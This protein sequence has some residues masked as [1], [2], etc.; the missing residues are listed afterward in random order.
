MAVTGLGGRRGKCQMYRRQVHSLVTA[1]RP[2]QMLHDC[3]HYI[4]YVLRTT[5]VQER[6]K[7]ERAGFTLKRLVTL[8]E[9]SDP[10]D[11]RRRALIAYHK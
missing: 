7:Q 11:D 5:P 3:W 2:D 9:S 4:P 6:D 1:R 8:P 10:T